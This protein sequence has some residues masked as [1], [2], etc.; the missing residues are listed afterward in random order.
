MREHEKPACVCGLCQRIRCL[1]AE[2]KR[3]ARDYEAR[4]R[5]RDRIQAGLEQ[6]VRELEAER[7]AL[8]AALELSERKARSIDGVGYHRCMICDQTADPA[9]PWIDHAPDCPFS[10]LQDMPRTGPRGLAPGMDL[11]AVL[12]DLEET[13]CQQP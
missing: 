13:P 1:E 5:R 6:R 11:R 10:V 3:M 4:L 2:N 8:R 12:E 9:E 7:V